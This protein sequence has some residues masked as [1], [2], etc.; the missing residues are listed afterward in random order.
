MESSIAEDLWGVVGALTSPSVAGKIVPTGDEYDGRATFNAL[1]NFVGPRRFAAMYQRDW[2]KAVARIVYV[3]L[4]HY[5]VAIV[6]CQ[7]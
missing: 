6:N 4:Q 5:V 7:D 2:V 3:F 1:P